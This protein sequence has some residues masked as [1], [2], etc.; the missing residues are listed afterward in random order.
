MKYK[1]QH[2]VHLS[3]WSLKSKPATVMSKNHIQKTNLLSVCLCMCLC[4]CVCVCVY[5]YIYIYLSRGKSPRKLPKEDLIS[6][7]RAV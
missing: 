5:A 2:F 3:L 1:E 6:K 4:V 7:L